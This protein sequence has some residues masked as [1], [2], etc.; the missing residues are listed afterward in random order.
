VKSIAIVSTEYFPFHGGL[1]LSVQRLSRELVKRN[2]DVFLIIPKLNNFS[3]FEIIDGVKV[4]RISTG[5]KS[6]Y[7]YSQNY[8]Q[9][10][11]FII[12]S[13]F[14]LR[15]LKPLVVYGLMFLPCGL[16]SS[17][18]SRFSFT[19]A[20]ARGA[21]VDNSF[22]KWYLKPFMRYLIK[23]NNLIFVFSKEHYHKVENLTGKKSLIVPNT[24]TVN[25]ITESKDELKRI[26]NLNSHKFN[27]LFV[28]GVRKCKGLKYL[29]Y[30]IKDI[31]CILNVVGKTVEMD[32]YLEVID[33]INELN[34]SHKVIF[35]GVKDSYT[36]NQFMKACDLYVQP[37]LREGMPPTVLEAMMMGM[38]LLVSDAGSLSEIVVD[39]YNGVVVKK[40]DSL[41][42]KDAILNLIDNP[43]ILKYFSN[44][45]LNI[46]NEKYSLKKVIDDFEKILDD[47]NVFD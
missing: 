3:D 24:V 40:A 12:K 41:M 30:A 26:L 6:N 31:D 15:K 42:L 18:C 43:S 13:Y 44:N 23:N 4:F 35:H 7:F 33:I 47:N 9:Q 32:G 34:I 16:I 22:N 2:Y 21:D 19:I 8:F 1:S 38:P 27:L 29:I 14:V 11:L 36:V 17:L 37:S 25:Q 39:G 45:S 46:S 10:L 5:I 20:H 28:G